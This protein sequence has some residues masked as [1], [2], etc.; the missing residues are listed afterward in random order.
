MKQGP[1]FLKYCLQYLPFHHDSE[2]LQWIHGVLPRSLCWLDPLIP[3]AAWGVACWLTVDSIP[4]N[5]PQ[6]DLLSCGSL[7]PVTTWDWGTK[8]CTFVRSEAHSRYKALPGICWD[9]CCKC[10]T[11]QVFCLLWWLLALPCFPHTLNKCSWELSPINFLH[12]NLYLRACVSETHPAAVAFH[13]N[14]QN[15]VGPRCWQSSSQSTNQVHRCSERLWREQG[16]EHAG[17][18]C[19]PKAAWKPALSEA[20]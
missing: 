7:Q 12:A 4:R 6:R 3:P 2:S 17:S 5:C 18:T 13:N 1:P 11:K 14:R 8:A 19:S 9:L 16:G 20:A 15:L 10:I